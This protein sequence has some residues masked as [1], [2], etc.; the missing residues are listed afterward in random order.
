MDADRNP[1]YLPGLYTGSQ[2]RK[3][4]QHI[5]QKPVEVMRELVKICPPG[6]AILDFCA[7]SGSTG[8]A[9]L[10]EGY[11]F[12]GIEKTKHYTD[13][14]ENRLAEALHTVSSQDDYALA[15]PTE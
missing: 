2:P 9:A 3:G 6:G 5:T 11:D 13:I 4:R 14:A 7:G 12:I 15:G 1:V 8:V 10:L